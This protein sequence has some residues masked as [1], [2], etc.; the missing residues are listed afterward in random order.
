L[1]NIISQKNLLS[2]EHSIPNESSLTKEL[3]FAWC[4]DADGNS[5]YRAQIIRGFA[6]H[7]DIETVN[8]KAVI[9]LQAVKKC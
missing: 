1:D 6:R 3:V 9:F 7:A 5:G 4:D 2:R 8:N